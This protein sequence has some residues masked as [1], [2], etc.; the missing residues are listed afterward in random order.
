MGHVHV[1]FGGAGGLGSAIVRHLVG[2]GQVVRAVVRDAERARAVLP[3]AARIE[4]ADATDARSTHKACREA[5]VIY[6]CI[7]VPFDEWATVLPEV[8]GNILASAHNAKAVL[9]FPGNVYGYGPL[10]K[11]PVTE[12]HPRAATSK[13]G[14]LR[15]QIEQQ[16]MDAHAAGRIRAVIPRFPHFYGPNVTAGLMLPIFR[17]ALS[18]AAATWPGRA[19]VPHD[20]I[21]IDDAARACVL[22]AETESAYGQAWHVPGAGPLTGRQ[23]VQMVYAAAGTEARIEPVGERALEFSGGA[24]ADTP[25]LAEL[26]YMYEEPL[27]L[28]GSKFAKAFAA[29]KFTP[30]KEGVRQTIAWLQEHSTV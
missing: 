26:M 27:L 12:D 4:V 15:N 9:V 13:K 7:N 17:T 25:E 29:F 30:H 23:F 5:A 22:L 16:L 21:Y 14:R 1:V 10:G 19:D 24:M 20:L 18:G 3:P 2:Q 8:T 11:K 6:H 28:D